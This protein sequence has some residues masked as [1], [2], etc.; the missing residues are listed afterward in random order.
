M[1]IDTYRRQE[2]TI[3]TAEDVKGRRVIRP[4]EKWPKDEPFNP[5]GVSVE[6][7]CKVIEG[8]KDE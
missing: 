1:N 7:V 6:E 2:F 4:E 3:L 5:K 8:M